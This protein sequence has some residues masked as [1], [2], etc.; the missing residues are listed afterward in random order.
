ML[1]VA[2]RVRASSLLSWLSTSFVNDVAATAVA[3]G[4]PFLSSYRVTCSEAG[5][6]TAPRA[7]RLGCR[8]FAS[9]ADNG[10]GATHTAERQ[11]HV[12]VAA[13]VLQQIAVRGLCQHLE[14][15]AQ[16]RIVVPEGELLLMVKSQGVTNDD[17]EAARIID[18][19]Q[20]SG[21]ILRYQGKVFIKPE[22]VAEMVVRAL[23]DTVEE[24]EVTPAQK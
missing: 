3:A 17:Q 20:I 14:K 11:R 2:Q 23:P 16:E 13:S 6:S 19:L 18:A 10:A 1:R 4:T 15:E 9:P 12:D 24:A 7:A 8:Y 5:C 22:E 21:V